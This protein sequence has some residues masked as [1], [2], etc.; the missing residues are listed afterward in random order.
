MVE[1]TDAKGQKAVYVY[2]DAGR[3]ETIRYFAAT[4]L[5]NPVKTVTFTYD[6]V[7]NLKSYDDGT[8][9]GTYGYDENHRKV[10]E[11]VNY[12]TFSLTNTYDYY[13]NGL[14]KTYTGPDNFPYGYTYDTN[15]QLTGVSI[16]GQGMITISAYN[17]TR[18][19]GMT[20]PGGA[21]KTFEY[22]PLMRVKKILSKDPGGNAL[23]DYAYTYDKVD[24]ITAKNTEHG[25][26]GYQYDDLYRLKDVD[27]PATAADEA[28]TYD[29]VGNRLTAADTAGNWSYNQNNELG[30]FDNTTYEY[31]VNGNMTQK[32]VDGSVTSYVYNTEDR[33]TQVWSGEVGSGSLAASYYYD[34]FGRRLWKEVSG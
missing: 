31:D 11:T 15:N 21:K 4:D 32:S 22:D 30:G 6:N 33:L 23:V 16:P 18:P 29:G 12:G 19:A 17:W 1:K 13:A 7:G 28:F 27:N 10:T 34:P 14:K 2:D 5:V 9:T 26:Y 3:M 8:T 25:G 20:L 24:N